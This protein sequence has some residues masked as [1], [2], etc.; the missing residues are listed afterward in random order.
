MK[1]RRNRHIFSGGGDE[2]EAQAIQEAVPLDPNAQI[3]EDA[4]AVPVDLDAQI[5]ADAQ[6]GPVLGVTALTGNANI[7]DEV[8]KLT[9]EEGYY[10][11]AMINAIGVCNST[12]KAKHNLLNPLNSEMF[13]CGDEC[14]KR[15]EIIRKTFERFI[16]Y[17]QQSD[18][19]GYIGSE[20]VLANTGTYLKNSLGSLGKKGF[21]SA[22]SLGSKGLTNASYAIQNPRAAVGNV[23]SA[24]GNAALQA[25]TAIGNAGYK[26]LTNLGKSAIALSNYFTRKAPATPVAQDQPVTGGRRRRTRRR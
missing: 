3:K 19:L 21:D 24:V 9:N 7:D 17:L 18:A 26:G 13:I 10:F 4:Q 15:A 14:K 6:A 22:V 20:R 2:P 5:K 12:M 8:A 25:P 16:P 11:R 1:T 23:G